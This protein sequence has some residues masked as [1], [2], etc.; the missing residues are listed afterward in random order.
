MNNFMKSCSPPKRSTLLMLLTATLLHGDDQL[1]IQQS[2]Q[3]IELRAGIL[4]RVISTAA[5]NVATQRLEVDGTP[6]ITSPADEVSFRLDKASPNRRPI[7]ID[8][9][10]GGTLTQ[11]TTV[12][13]ATDALEI[14]Q[15]DSDQSPETVAWHE[16]GTFKGGDLG[17]TF[18]LQ[19]SLLSRPDPSVQQLILRN[20]VTREP[21]LR[22]LSINLVYQVHS[23][24]PVI[25]KWVEFHNNSQTW[26]KV[27]ELVMEDLDLDADFRHQVLLTP[28]ER[29]AGSSIIGFG[30]HSQTTGVVCASEVPSALRSIG[31]TGAM[32]Y[33][34][35]HFE[36]ILGPGESFV[37]EPVFMFGYAGEVIETVSARS[38]P[39]DRV[40]EGPF[41]AFLETHLGVAATQV[42]SASPVW[43]TWTNFAEN[44]DDA[45]I[46]QQA[47]LAARCG[48]KTFQIDD[49][50]QHDRLGVTP[51][52]ET[53]P[54]FEA[55]SRYVRSQGLRL[56]LW[57]SCFRSRDS[58]DLQVLPGAAS[59]PE[60][61][62]LDGVAM[63]FASPW[64][65]YFGHQLA[66]L[67]DQYGASYFKLDFT[68]IK[69]GDFSRENESRSKKESLLRGL[70]GL[71]RSQE[72][73]RQQAP[74]V[75]N[76]ITHEIYWGTPGVPCDL[77]AI[78]HAVT[79]HIPPND[80]S[81]TVHWKQRFGASDVWAKADP[82][83]L[84]AQLIQG[85]YNARQR[86][87]EHRGLPLESVEYYGAATINANGSLSPEIQDRQVCSWLMG[88]PMV[89]A[90]DLTSLTEEN[91]DRYRNRFELLERLH[92]TY[93][94]Y[95]HFQYSGVPE[96][97]D[98][99]WHWWGK[100]D[101]NGA[102]AVVVI[103]GNE[104][105]DQR[106]INIPW[107]EPDSSYEVR[108]L[109]ADKSLGTFNGEELING[110]LQLALPAYGQEILE[111]I[112]P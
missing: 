3:Q 60:I 109:F 91:I 112:Q 86:F 78:K 37:S 90:G 85:C 94:I 18:D 102:G 7:G 76:Q 67:H 19:N 69:Y 51:N 58:Q 10:T 45:I 14:D 70:R 32:G 55:T 6:L 99:D 27:S 83:K 20:R 98:T 35:E 15:E 75:S 9:Q 47:E 44:I 65:E 93:G 48:F 84:A 57:V 61:R 82:V 74:A 89:F 46:R 108:A 5:A 36:W 42:E 71:L 64:S 23:N 81:G 80:Y 68:N 52:P 105:A 101:K 100:L 62:R 77:A 11:K 107:V 97:T 56:G 88:A 63:S 12:S 53:F 22:G 38:L 41:Q 79:Y 17:C 21:E 26:L 2:G 87:Y 39:L 24:F 104:G 34:P 95:H 92:A 1:A 50:W 72:V 43:C 103:R 31:P 110:R 66:G 49:G 16:I 28:S 106:A 33:N 59:V 73:L 13:D 111:V 30:N 4:H 25:R 96:P 29:G 40:I 8:P 54:D